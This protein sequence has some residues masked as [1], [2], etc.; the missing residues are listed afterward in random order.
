MQTLAKRIGVHRGAALI[1]DYGKDGPYGDS[2]VAIRDHKKVDVSD[3]DHGRVD[4]CLIW[5]GGND[6]LMCGGLKNNY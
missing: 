1:V 6:K 3:L 4:N 2:L 5:R